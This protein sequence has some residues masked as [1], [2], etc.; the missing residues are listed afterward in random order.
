MDGRAWPAIVIFHHLMFYALAERDLAT[1]EF[2][3]ELRNEWKVPPCC[4]SKQGIFAQSR[5]IQIYASKRF[6][7][8][9]VIAEEARTYI[10]TM[11]QLI[12]CAQGIKSRGIW[13]DIG[14]EF[15]AD[16]ASMRVCSDFGHLQ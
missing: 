6:A 3:D 9:K 7:K 8:V 11:S 4:M 16:A 10:K 13:P 12:M 14:S 5:Y 15:A 2:S 1:S